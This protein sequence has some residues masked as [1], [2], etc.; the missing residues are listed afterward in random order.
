MMDPGALGTLIIGLE[1]V[2][3]DNEAN[4]HPRRSGWRAEASRQ[5]RTRF[6]VVAG[7]LRTVADRLDR[8]TGQTE[9][10]TR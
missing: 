8:P 10:A 5:R 3:L 9:L 4:E 7:W 2:R 6:V 1:S